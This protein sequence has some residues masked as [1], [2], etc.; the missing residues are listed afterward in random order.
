MEQNHIRGNCRHLA[1]SFAVVSLAVVG[2]VAVAARK[3]GQR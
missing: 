1:L 2:G 3:T